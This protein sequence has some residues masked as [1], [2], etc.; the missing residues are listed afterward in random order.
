MPCRT[1]TAVSGAVSPEPPAASVLQK[2]YGETSATTSMSA[3]E[4]FMSGA[5]L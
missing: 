4:V 2:T 5:Q 3:A 1:P